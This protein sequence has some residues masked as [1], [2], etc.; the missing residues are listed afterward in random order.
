MEILSLME[1]DHKG[2]TPELSLMAKEQRS[3]S[4][5]AKENIKQCAAERKGAAIEV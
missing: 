1:K 5:K 4:Y 2:V 3:S